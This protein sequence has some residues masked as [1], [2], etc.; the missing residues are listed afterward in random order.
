M[1]YMTFDSNPM[2]CELVFTPVPED[3]ASFTFYP[4]K[5]EI[6]IGLT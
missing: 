6:N 3:F 2:F 4:N 5:D 1:D